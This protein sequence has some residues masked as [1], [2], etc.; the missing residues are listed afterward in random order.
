MPLTSAEKRIVAKKIKIIKRIT[1][2]AL[3]DIDGAKISLPYRK[4]YPEPVM[5]EEIKTFRENLQTCAYE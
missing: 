4:E 3:W 5:A 1:A 2:S